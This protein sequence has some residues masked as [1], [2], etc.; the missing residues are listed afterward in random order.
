MIKNYFKL[1]WRNLIKYKLFS[2]IKLFGLIVGVTASLLIANY[3]YYELSYDQFHEKGDRIAQVAMEYTMD[4][5]NDIMFYTGNKVAQALKTDFPEIENTCKVIRYRQPVKF[6]DKLFEQSRIYFADS[7]FFNIF[8]FDLIQ[9]QKNE[10]LNKPNQ[11]VLS[12]SSAK[13]YFGDS[14]PVGQSLRIGSTKEYVVIGIMKDPPINSHM[15]PAMVASFASLRD[16][17]PERLTWWNANYATYALLRPNVE[18]SQM[19]DKLYQYMQERHEETGFEKGGE[20]YMTFKLVPL[21]DLRL[22]TKVPGFFEPNGDIRY[23]YILL[24]VGVLTLLIGVTTYINLSSISSSERAS[25]IAI[26]KVMGAQRKQIFGQHLGESIMVTFAAIFIAYILSRP[27]TPVFNHLFDRQLDW[28]LMVQPLTIL[29]ILI[30]G[31]ILSFISGFYPAMIVSKFQPSQVFRGQHGGGKTG[32]WLRNGFII[33]QFGISVFL[34]ICTGVLMGQ[35]NF[36]Q[37]SELGYDKDHVIALPADRKIVD[38]I[39][40]FKTNFKE[41]PS[42]KN[43]SLTYETPVHI[44][45]GYNI[46]PT[47]ND[48]DGA[49][50]T[51]IPVDQEFLQTM[52][53]KL[54]AGQDLTKNDVELIKNIQAG[55]DSTSAYP[56]LVNESQASRFG[57]TPEEAINKIVYFR[58][59][60]V[61]KGV[62]KNFHFSSLHEPIKELVIFP[63]TYGGVLLVKMNGQNIQSSIN[64]L[65]A[66]WKTLAPHRPFSYKFLDEEI[67]EMYQAENQTANLV[68]TFSLIAILLACL[69]LFGI[70]SFSIFKRTKEIGVRKVLGASI[71]SII[72]LLSMDFLKLVVI[73]FVIAGPIAWYLMNQWLENFAYRIGIPWWLILV[74]GLLSLLIAFITVSFQSIKVA[75]SNP[76]ESLRNE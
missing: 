32:S 35:L 50:V 75:L 25:N 37:Q 31:I 59:R 2:L 34:M 71:G 47:S 22:K 3:I 18:Q 21:K 54:S 30:G 8:S 55:S 36:I 9:G 72:S 67:A 66:K 42:I 63:D 15:K 57:W 39:E 70:A 23:I 51:A 1:A 17:A 61:I 48:K 41:N 69:G 11:V 40:R 38:K 58:G 27:L 60:S 68:K 7:S 45:G 49:V 33:F 62:V 28:S 65:E 43:I 10:M 44:G 64:F 76:V 13:K 53:I 26:Q 29:A 52:N 5:E 12:V 46:S 74:V 6:G 20:D 4:G 14:N 56:I 16:A 19:N 73:A 24:I